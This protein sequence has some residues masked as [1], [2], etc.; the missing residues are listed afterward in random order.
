MLRKLGFIDAGAMVQPKGRVACEID[1]AGRPLRNPKQAAWGCV[2]KSWRWQGLPAGAGVRRGRSD[3]LR[4]SARRRRAGSR[5][6]RAAGH[7]F[8]RCFPPADELLTAEL[9]VNGTFGGLDKHQLVA[10][11]SC[12]VPV[13]RTNVS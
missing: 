5:W 6:L 11:V 3:A 13:D 8:H 10:L 2:Y 4:W 1:A 9:L 12:L 7:A